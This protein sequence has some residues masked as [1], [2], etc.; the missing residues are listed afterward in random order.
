MCED[1]LSLQKDC[2]KDALKA[3]LATTIY[4]WKLRWLAMA[5]NGHL[6]MAKASLIW[7]IT[8]QNLASLNVMK[9]RVSAITLHLE[10]LLL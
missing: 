6:G 2:N 10:K 7:C 3:L 8:M 5:A 1:L 9:S 4:Y